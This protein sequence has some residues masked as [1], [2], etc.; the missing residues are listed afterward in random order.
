MAQAAD[1]FTEQDYRDADTVLESALTGG[2]MISDLL[3]QAQLSGLSQT[4]QALV[5]LLALRAYGETEEDAEYAVD[6]ADRCFIA[7][8][9]WG[10]DLAVRPSAKLEEVSHD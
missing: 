4:V 2:S 10:D 8:P 9:F 6:A 1:R 7:G 3:L 5:Y